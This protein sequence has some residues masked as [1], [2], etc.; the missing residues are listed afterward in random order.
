[1]DMT[2]VGSTHCKFI[3]LVTIEN[4]Q[5]VNDP[6]GETIHR[7]LVVKG[8]YSNVE[9]VRTSKTLKMIVNAKS[10]KDAEKIVS[11][12]CKDLRIF[13]P[14]ISECIVRSIGKAR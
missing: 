4:K 2:E 5:F 3:V 10:E 9:S 11:D 6:E 8:G 14:V 13:N 1:M 7:D 12:L